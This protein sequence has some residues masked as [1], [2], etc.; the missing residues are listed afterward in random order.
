M[1][2]ASPARPPSRLLTLAEV[3]ALGELGA[4]F[5]G[6]RWLSRLPRGDGHPVLVLPGFLAAD[7][8]TWPLRW[9]LKRLGYDARGWGLGR[10][11]RVD[12]ARIGE[13]AALLQRIHQEAGQ[14]VSLV[15]W[16]LGGVFARELAKHRPDVV[17]QVVTLGSPISGERDHTNASRLF[18]YLNRK[19]PDP[20][21]SPR[22][23]AIA[24]PPPVPTTAILTRSDGI[25][26]W[27]G[28]L[29]QGDNAHAR[30]ENIVVRAS[31]CG[32]GFNPS[33]MIVIADR[34]RLSDGHWQPFVPAPGQGWLFPPQIDTRAEATPL[35]RGK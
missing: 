7:G 26:H 18:A 13:M 6:Q 4:F 25:V 11:V 23:A 21:D 29:Q 33:V 10:N 19:G 15:G 31:H 5:A 34:L 2:P 35:A 32:L 8:S 27:R 30:T 22:F 17:R 24:S 28:A 14:R 16:S 12:E 3:R 9:L 20:F 1:S